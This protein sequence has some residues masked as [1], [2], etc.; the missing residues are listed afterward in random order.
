MSRENGANVAPKLTEGEQDLIIEMENGY[1][2]QTDC[3]GGNP[4]LRRLKDGESVSSNASTEGIAKEGA[5]SC[6]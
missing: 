5:D 6:C 3:L 1:Q 2:I 4:V